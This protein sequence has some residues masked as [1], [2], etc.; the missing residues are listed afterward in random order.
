MRSAPH[1]QD[2]LA[3]VQLVILDVDGVLTD[4]GCFI[5]GADEIKKFNARD[6]SGIKY[7]MR[8]GI[9][10]ALVSGR[11]TG[12]TAQLAQELGIA[13]V[14]QKALRKW[15]VVEE[16]LKRKG[17]D[18]DQVAYVGD[19]LV[20]L[21]VMARVGVSI[22]VADAVAEVTDRADAVTTLPGGA[23]AVRE[24]VE[25]V[26]KAQGKWE[27]ILARYVESPSAEEGKPS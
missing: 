4:G 18:P 7:L 20:D 12:A 25:W 2:Q 24:V 8:S 9:E 3:A 19:D 15:P 16:L 1:L 27:A 17:L 10:V 11:E 6:G 23:G 14:H 13:E 22:A 5:G 21:P 26:L